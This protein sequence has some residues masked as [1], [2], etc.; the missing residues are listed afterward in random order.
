MICVPY[1]WVR[2]HFL[3]TW[4]VH[5][6]LA[7]FWLEIKVNCCNPF[8]GNKLQWLHSHH[9]LLIMSL[10][11]RTNE[12]EPLVLKVPCKRSSHHQE[13]TFSGTLMDNSL[14]YL[15]AT[16]NPWRLCFGSTRLACCLGGVPGIPHVLLDFFW[17]F[18]LL[19]LECQ[20]TPTKNHLA[21]V[22]GPKI[23][24][25]VN[26]HSDIVCEKEA[27][28][29]VF[30]VHLLPFCSSLLSQRQF[31]AWR[32]RRVPFDP[33]S[34]PFLHGASSPWW[35]FWWSKSVIHRLLELRNCW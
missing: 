34:H 10:S 11:I 21:D 6:K 1:S 14:V 20:N 7:I 28:S 16:G 32:K 29:A 23:A 15:A 33:N 8:Q 30:S 26:K 13:N 25:T 27:S 9:K 17:M 18:L 19:S 5:I 31:S 2:T 12:C 22:F 24:Y 35:S 3:T 4:W